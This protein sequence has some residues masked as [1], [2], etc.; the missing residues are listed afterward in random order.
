MKDAAAVSA[1]FDVTIAN[2]DTTVLELCP[3]K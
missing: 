2:A 3:L 1:T